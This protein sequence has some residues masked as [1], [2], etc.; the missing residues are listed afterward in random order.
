[1]T[2]HLLSL[3][4]HQTGG[5]SPDGYILTRC[6]QEGV[7]AA[8]GCLSLTTPGESP[9]ASLCVTLPSDLGG[10]RREQLCTVRTCHNPL[11]VLVSQQTIHPPRQGPEALCTH[12]W[13]GTGPALTV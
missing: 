8:V 12:T 5:S 6:P 4:S 13:L 10:A 7:K 2:G 1:M 3:T 11:R 9:L